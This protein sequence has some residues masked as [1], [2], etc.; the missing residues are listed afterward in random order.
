M[1]V[2]VVHNSYQRRGGED[3]VAFAESRLLEAHGHTVI[4]YERHNDELRNC[5]ARGALIA[6][7]ETVWSSMSFRAMKG[8]IAKEKPDVAHFHNT[9]PLISPAAYYAC[10]EADVPVVQTLHNY[11]L[12]CPVAT[13]LRDGQICQSCLG[14]SVAWRGVVHGCYRGSRPAT[15][16][17]AAMLAVHRAL[18]TWQTKVDAYIALSEFARRKFIEGGL[19]GE[20]VV[21]K[22]NFVHPDPGAKHGPGEYALHVGRLSQEKGLHLLL[23]A[24]GQLQQRIPLRIAG[25]GP[26][27]EAL[28]S[29]IE[30]KGLREVELLGH[31]APTE[32]ITL[33][34]HAR[35]LVFPSM[36]FE[37]FPMS[38]AGAF[39]CG[40]PVIAPLLGTM[41]EIIAAGISGLHFSAGDALDLAARVEWAWTHAAEMQE[42]GRN[43]CEEYRTK[44][45]PERNYEKL[46]E[47]Y[48][49]VIKN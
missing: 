44:Y 5:G 16:A 42:M 40:L 41:A 20:R 25:D 2:L 39:A 29:E 27:R 33:M 9:L 18:G 10:A 46:W 1:K 34:H 15:A 23:E 24:W 4:H 32:I 35:F 12:L 49:S 7:I 31:V 26:L 19:P 22:P 14:R 6:G 43:A 37:G 30:K 48:N 36:W 47:I 21:V 38:I 11:R 45:T 3:T 13:F 28:A 17:V 8:L